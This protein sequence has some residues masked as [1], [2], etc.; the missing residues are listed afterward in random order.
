MERDRY[1]LKSILFFPEFIPFLY[2]PVLPFSP[3]A[4][5]ETSKAA[6]YGS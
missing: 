5:F 6:C 2:S 4:I 1:K 3:L